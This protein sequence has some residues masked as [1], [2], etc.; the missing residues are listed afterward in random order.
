MKTLTVISL[1]AVVSQA[2][3]YAGTKGQKNK[4]LKQSV[5]RNGFGIDLTHCGPD[6]SDDEFQFA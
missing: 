5:L 1:G 6:L 3:A 2:L 4:M